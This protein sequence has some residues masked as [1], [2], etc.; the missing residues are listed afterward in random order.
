MKHTW[1]QRNIDNARASVWGLKIA[2]LDKQQE[3]V[4]LQLLV[5]QAQERLREVES[6]GNRT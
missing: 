2:V 1:E 4:N 3:V 5:E 6:H